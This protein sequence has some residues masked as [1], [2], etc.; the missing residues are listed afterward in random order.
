MT[1]SNR[2]SR[3]DRKARRGRVYAEHRRAAADERDPEAARLARARTR[4]RRTVTARV[5]FVAGTVVG[6][7]HL[8]FHVAGSPSALS[9]VLVGYPT[10]GVLIVAG[11]FALGA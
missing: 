5:L 9:D 3:R 2:G 8:G 10:A 1:S 11:A 4:R 7:Q 6:L